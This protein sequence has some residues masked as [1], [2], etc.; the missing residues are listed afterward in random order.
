VSR[1][2]FVAACVVLSSLGEAGFVLE[3]TNQM[4]EFFLVLG[5]FL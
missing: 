3:S 1:L 4:F 5:M 2:I